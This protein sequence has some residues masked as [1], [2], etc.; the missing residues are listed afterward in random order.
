MNGIARISIAPE[1]LKRFAVDGREPRSVILI[2]ITAVYFQCARA[3]MRSKLWDAA[4]HADKAALPS[5]GQM[6]V[7]AAGDTTAGFDQVA[8]D[9]ELPER[10]KKTLY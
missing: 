10:Q 2:E 9:R 1:L 5:A 8:Y 6:M 7:A 3:I 4:R